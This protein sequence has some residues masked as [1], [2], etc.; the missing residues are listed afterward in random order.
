MTMSICDSSDWHPAY[1]QYTQP[2]TSAP[3]PR[4]DWSPRVGLAG[5]RSRARYQKQ[6]L[7]GRLTPSTVPSIH[8]GHRRADQTVK[9]EAR[10]DGRRICSN[11]M[12]GSLHEQC[13]LGAGLSTPV[14]CG[15]PQSPNTTRSSIGTKRDSDLNDDHCATK[16]LTYWRWTSLGRVN[17]VASERALI[18]CRSSDAWRP[19]EVGFRALHIDLTNLFNVVFGEYP[20]IQANKSFTGAVQEVLIG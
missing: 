14:P 6:R 8:P 16:H 9:N 7:V 5:T 19:G 17:V 4:H 2:K 18:G 15:I 12:A 3:A 1:Y 11:Q 10:A 13:W 20:W